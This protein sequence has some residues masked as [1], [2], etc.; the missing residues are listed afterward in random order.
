MTSQDRPIRLQR[1][2]LAVPATRPRFLAKAAE[3]AAD[4][5]FLDLEDAVAPAHKEDARAQAIR[6][7]REV[8]WERRQWPCG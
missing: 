5:L 1:S 3:S 8:D 7:L 6:A 2:E 4:A